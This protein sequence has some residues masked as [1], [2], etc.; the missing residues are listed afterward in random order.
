MAK[1]LMF[2]EEARQKI[3]LGIQKLVQAIKA[4]LGPAGKNVIIE[5]KF[6]SPQAANDGVTVSKEIELED[7]FENIGTKLVHS[8]G[9]KTNDV[10]GDGTSSAMILAEAIY[11]EGLKNVAAGANPVALKR[12][13]D[14]AVAA[15][16]EELKRMSKPVKGIDDYRHVA[17]ISANNDTVIGDLIAQAV[18]KVGKEGVVTVE[19]SKSFKT[20]LE[21]VEGLQFD[22]GYISPYFINRPEQL[23][24]EFEDAY[25]IISE[26][27]ISN[28]TEFV[29]ILE[30]VA[31]T[32]KPLLVIAED[33]EG[34][35]LAALVINRLR[36]VMLSCAVKAPAFGDRRKAILQDIAIVTG[37]KVVS[38]DLGIKLEGLKL[39]ELGRAKR[40]KIEKEKT[41]IIQGYGDRD[42]IDAR[43]SEIRTLI[44]K[45]T[46]D[47]DREKLEERLAKLVGGVAVVKVG[48]A[49]EAEMKEKKLRVED[50]V[51]ATQAAA[52]EGVV[53]GGGIAYLRAAGAIQGLPLE[54]D[55]KT[56]ATIVAKA[57]ESLLFNISANAGMDG[58]M[59]VAEAKERPQE[60]GLDVIS[61]R[62]VNMFE[63]GIIDP[64]KVVK[65]AVQN[66]ASIA[67]LLLSTKTLVTEL[68]E[69]KKAVAGA[70]K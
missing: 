2:D 10:A 12:G 58:S 60:E 15:V 53:A 7:P 47:Y 1:Q 34:E 11:A 14:K 67:S 42:K 65:S 19:E 16:V 9:D 40:V 29:P 25:I 13:I 4:T 64:T 43:I 55:E 30:R 37:G 26:K 56:G 57:M 8:V 46:S 27:K 41:T 28:I 18:D 49:T 39:E 69:K 54:G 59:I 20:E 62:F 61:G 6:G 22:K 50:A 35:A 45:S 51:N 66:A 21:F 33:V 44:G 63:A 24:V 32:G 52:E 17:T 3:S 23:T 38:E 70:L 36:G 48:G 5:K 68:K 31:Q